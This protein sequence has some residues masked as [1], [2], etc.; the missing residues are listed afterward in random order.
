MT[1]PVC[2]HFFIDLLIDY[3]IQDGKE[4]V[5]WYGSCAVAHFFTAYEIFIIRKYIYKKLL[6]IK[7]TMVAELCKMKVGCP[8]K[9]YR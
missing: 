6:D 2:N 4:I 5:R 1:N 8:R 9:L 7:L 3:I